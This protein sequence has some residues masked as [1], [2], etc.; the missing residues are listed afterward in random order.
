MALEI[1]ESADCIILT[2]G[3]VEKTL[4]KAEHGQNLGGVRAFFAK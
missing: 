1:C 4:K 3:G 2:L